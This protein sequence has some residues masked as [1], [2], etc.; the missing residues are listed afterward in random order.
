MVLWENRSE[1]A[2]SCRSVRPLT[3]LVD[4]TDRQDEMNVTCSVDGCGKTPIARGWCSAHYARW[5]KHGDVTV[6][7]SPGIPAGVC[8][9][10]GCDSPTK[11]HG[12]CAKHYQRF[13][14]YGDPLDAGR[15]GKR[16]QPVVDYLGAHKRVYRA[17]GK[18]SDQPCHHCGDRAT[19]WAYDH[20]DPA[21]L[22]G[23]TRDAFAVRY[24]LDPVYY[25]PLCGPCHAKFDADARVAP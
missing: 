20:L 13:K 2:R 10:E 19:Q 1:A 22:I 12:Y 9:I 5:H 17:K 3:H 14:K 15:V 8:K 4:S 21:E 6:V 18:A 23:V 24:S 11:G 16:P 7:K 25:L